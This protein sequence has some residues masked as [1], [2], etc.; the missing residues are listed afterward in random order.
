M[1][2]VKIGSSIK[3]KL[4]SQIKIYLFINVLKVY[5]DNII[6]LDTYYF[7]LDKI[8]FYHLNFCLD[9]NDFR[10]KD[11]YFILIFIILMRNKNW[12][13]AH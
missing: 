4:L 11:T 8:Y 5:K 3:K 7:I 9:I 1:R 6:K 13:F 12:N 2:K 10:L